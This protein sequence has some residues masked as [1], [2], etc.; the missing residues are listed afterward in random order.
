M[1]EMGEAGKGWR[2][3]G[4]ERLQREAGRQWAQ[5]EHCVSH[6]MLFC[7]FFTFRD[8]DLSLSNCITVMVEPF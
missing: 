5:E 4:S 6:C 8:T 3:R 2:E 1:S 7:F